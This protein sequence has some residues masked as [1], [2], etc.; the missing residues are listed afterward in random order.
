M[1]PPDGSVLDGAVHALDLAIIRHDD[2][3]A[4]MFGPVPSG[5]GLW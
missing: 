1:E 3:G 4:L 2:F 5:E